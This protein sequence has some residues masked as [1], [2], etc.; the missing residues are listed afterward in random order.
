MERLETKRD[1]LQCVVEKAERLEELV[2][3]FSYIDISTTKAFLTSAIGELSTSNINYAYFG[4]RSIEEILCRE[5]L[6]HIF[7]FLYVFERF[8]Y[9][10][11][12]QTFYSIIYTQPPSSNDIT[13]YE[14]WISFDI[15]VNNNNNLVQISDMLFLYEKHYPTYIKI[16]PLKL[17]SINYLLNKL[18]LNFINLKIGAQGISLINKI[19]N[20]IKYT[21]NNKLIPFKLK[22]WIS[23]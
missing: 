3:L 16:N 6:M 10:I 14:T 21:E 5:L 22:E 20:K 1:S 13:H 4:V 15:N 11:I 2:K 23:Y 9:C 12:S 18:N 17:L 19:I 8:K 7:S